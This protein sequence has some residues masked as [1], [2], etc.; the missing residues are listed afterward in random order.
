M[1]RSVVLLAVALAVAPSAAPGSDRPNVLMIAVDDLNDWVGCLGGHPQVLTPNIDRLAER[2]TLFTNAHCQ[3]PLCN[4]S[5][6]SILT[7]LRPSTTGVYGL[8]PWF[9]EVEELA[10]VV[11]LPQ[12]L[13]ANGYT[14]SS[15]GKVYHG[16]YPP[17]R[18][19]EIEFDE[20]GPG[21]SVG[22]VPDH[23]LI[24]PTPGGN[25]PLM[26]WGTFPHQDEEKGDWRVASWAVDRLE[27]GPP[28]PFFLAVGFFLPHVPCY[29]TQ[30]WFDMYPDESLIMPRVFRG[31][32][33]DTPEFSWYLHWA[34]PEPRLSWME[35]AGAWRPLVRSY[36]ACT[37]FVDAQVG[38]VLDALE[39]SGRLDDTIV[40]LWSDHGYHLGEKEISGKNTLW[41]PSTRVPLIFAG[42]GVEAGARCDR[43]VELLDLYPTL[44]DLLGLPD[45]PG[46]PLEGHSLAPLLADASADRPWPA[47]TTHNQGNHGIRTDR[48]RFIRYADGSEELYDLTADPEEWTNL[49]LDPSYE[50]ILAEHRRWLPEVDV[51]AAP[52]SAHRVLAFDGESAVWE[53]RPIDPAELQP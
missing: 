18:D 5:R 16:G 33:G 12:H 1:R 22:A 52:G 53:G 35:S 27:S 17:A 47:I 40:I 8:A 25:H 45:R 46:R 10:D 51:P 24:G 50:P 31:D 3:A 7:G 41:E 19:R 20:Y 15:V 38:R 37:S 26:D 14:A 49:A 32:R 30:E 13:R 39:A 6:T 4:S 28:E 44:I 2:G 48:W 23:K 9:R 29:A 34:L 42:P 21:A 36:L 43:P 11:S